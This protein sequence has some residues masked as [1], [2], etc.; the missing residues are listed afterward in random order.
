M[1]QVVLIRHREHSDVTTYAD[2][3]V[4]DKGNHTFFCKAMELG[5]KDNKQGESRIPAGK[6]MMVL[7]YSESFKRHLWELKQVPNRSEVKIHIANYYR[8]LRGCIALG[9]AIKDIGSAKVQG[10]MGRPDGVDDMSLST[11]AFDEFMKSMEGAKTACI[12]IIDLF[13]N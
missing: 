9:K 7:E 12:T 6:Y 2:F 11:P 1:K 3:H 4:Y 8:E 13:S 10:L 5:W